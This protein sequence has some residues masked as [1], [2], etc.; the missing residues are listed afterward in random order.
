MYIQRLLGRYPFAGSD[1]SHQYLLSKNDG[2][3]KGNHLKMVGSDLEK[4]ILIFDLNIKDKSGK[5]FCSF[6]VQTSL[7]V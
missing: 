6:F 1:R 7:P 4:I 3:K 2:F 5:N